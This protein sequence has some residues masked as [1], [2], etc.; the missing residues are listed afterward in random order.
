MEPSV[1][2]FKLVLL[3]D[4][5]VGKTSILLRYIENQFSEVTSSQPVSEKLKKVMVN[6]REMVL[7]IWDT[8][9][10]ERYKS[11]ETHYYRDADAAILVYSVVD[12]ESFSSVC[13]Y[14]LRETQRYLPDEATIPILLVGNKIDLADTMGEYVP[15]PSVR[16]YADAYGILKP[17]ECSAKT[18]H[19][20]H[21]IFSSVASDLYKRHL[22][23][24]PRRQH[25][26]KLSGE[27]N[28]SRSCCSGT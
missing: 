11:L 2:Q 13:D 24:Y 19:N 26:Q 23:A 28:S 16:E 21:K 3:G 18:G 8:A 22:K 6:G 20:I 12:E 14:W 15:M 9:G 7:E 1:F 25:G 17:M 5:D 10:Q 27:E 4:P